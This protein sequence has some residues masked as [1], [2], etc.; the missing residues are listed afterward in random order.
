[1][2]IR[3]RLVIFGL[4]LALFAAEGIFRLCGMS[5]GVPPVPY[6]SSKFV[7]RA[8]YAGNS[9]TGWQLKPGNYQLLQGGRDRAVKISINPDASRVTRK[10]NTAYSRAISKIICIGDSFIFGEG[11]D[12]EETLPWRLQEL[13]PDR[14]VINHGVGGFGTCQ[15]MLRLSQLRE[16]L[17]HGDI[18]VY[19][20]SSFHEERNTAD[21]RQDYWI[22][23][24]SPNHQSSYPRCRKN[25]NQ[26]VRE[27]SKVWEIIMPL[28]GRSVLSKIFTDAWLSVLAI[29]SVQNQRELTFSL[30]E[31]M[32]D[33]SAARGASLIVLLQ[34][35]PSDAAIDYQKFLDR[36]AI[37]Y[38]DGTD[39][40][41]RHHLKLPDGHPGSEM[42]ELWA[43]KLSV[44]LSKATEEPSK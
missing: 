40:A 11:L 17:S 9:L 16:L 18:V 33:I 26:I 36:S 6:E 3:F 28:T 8:P 32:K 29:R 19:G 30:L 13:L 20:L 14:N 21:P 15:T 35:F 10:E 42:A 34:E 44:F 7:F 38:V 5:A 22:A 23:I 41:Y 31:K 4:V 27:D 39:I 37:N 2:F 24:S 12:D 1:M 43:K 25:D